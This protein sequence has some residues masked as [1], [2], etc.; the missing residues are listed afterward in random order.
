MSKS[1]MFLK[2]KNTNEIYCWGNN[3]YGQLGLGDFY[4][5]K[6]PTK[7][8][9]LF[10]SPIKQIACGSQHTL[11]ICE[12]NEIFSWGGESSW[13]IRIGIVV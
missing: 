4:H 5:V 1:A 7:M 13:T 11:A 8:T 10:I 2:K 9:F 3:N 12:N 6:I